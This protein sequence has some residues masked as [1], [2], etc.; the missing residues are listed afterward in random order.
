MKLKVTLLSDLCVSAGE[1]YNAY[2][3]IEA[4]YDEYGIPFIPAKR[5]KGCIR[6]AALELVEWG[7]YDKT[8]YESLFGKEGKERTKFLTAHSRF[9]S[10]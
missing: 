6:E 3:D 10:I 4:V 9:H 7:V 5:L 2:V 1:S 8:V